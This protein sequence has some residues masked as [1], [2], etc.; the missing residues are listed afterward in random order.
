M[1]IIET[2]I[3]EPAADDSGRRVYVGQKTAQKVFGELKE[4]LK[5]TGHLPDEYFLLNSHINDGE[6]F[7]EE[8]DVMCYVNWGSNEGIYLYITLRFRN[9]KG[10]L[11]Y[12][13]FATG[14][15]LSESDTALDHMYLTASACTKA[16]HSPGIHSRFILTKGTD[17]NEE[18]NTAV[19]KGEVKLSLI[20]TE[21]ELPHMSGFKITRMLNDE[22]IEIKLTDAEL[23][24]A[25]DCQEDKNYSSYI[26]KTLN[27]LDAGDEILRGCAIDKIIADEG[28]MCSITAKFTENKNIRNMPCYDAAYS[29]IEEELKLVE[30]A[31]L[32]PN[33]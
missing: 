12:K 33:S 32:L 20:T 30:K 13:E 21:S 22:K 8:A 23:S 24:D 5:S 14:K 1:S 16:F 29:A 7:P 6:L 15:T 18:Q 31:D 4:H 26:E 3:Y 28:L 10:D 2:E 17:N 11:Q 19:K 9:E 25:Y 27:E